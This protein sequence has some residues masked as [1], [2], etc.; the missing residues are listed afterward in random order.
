M[1]WDCVDVS[2]MKRRLW[3]RGTAQVYVGV[4]DCGC[5][6][7]QRDDDEMVLAPRTNDTPEV[8]RESRAAKL[9]T[10]RYMK[11]GGRLIM[12]R[13]AVEIDRDDEVRSQLWARWGLYV[14]CCRFVRAATGTWRLGTRVTGARVTLILLGLSSRSRNSTNWRGMPGTHRHCGNALLLRLTIMHAC[15]V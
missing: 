5:G 14:G 2:G 13:S 6:T 12:T 11:D 15:T 7:L 4:S 8:L 3:L 1:V 9:G 10:V